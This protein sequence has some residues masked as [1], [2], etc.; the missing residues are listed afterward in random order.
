M[1]VGCSG[2]MLDTFIGLGGDCSGN[3]LVLD[4]RLLI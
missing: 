2:D 4:P 3:R 1:R